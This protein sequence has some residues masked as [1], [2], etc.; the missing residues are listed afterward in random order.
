MPLRRSSATT[1]IAFWSGRSSSRRD[2]A[3]QR[4]HPGAGRPQYR[5]GDCRCG[6]GGH[7]DDP[8]GILVVM[9]SDHAISDEERLRRGR[10]AGGQSGSRRQA[11][12]VRHQAGRPAHRYGY[13]QQGAPLDGFDGQPLRSRLSPRSPMPATAQRYLDEGGYFWNSGIVRLRRARLPGR[14]ARLAP[15]VVDA[16]RNAL[17]WRQAR[18]GLSAPRRGGLCQGARTSPSTMP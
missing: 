15:A 8:D 14:A 9:P 18:P 6:A 7:A 3:A 11:R 1:T 13:I 10:A 2:L 17:G 12:A 5:A 4:D 16:A